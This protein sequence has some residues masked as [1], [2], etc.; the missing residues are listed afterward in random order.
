MTLT[1]SHASYH[2]WSGGAAHG[3]PAFKDP[4][5]TTR[6]ADR[7][8]WLTGQLEAPSWGVVQNYDGAAMS[9]GILNNIAVSPKDNTQGSFF[10]LLRRILD[11]ARGMTVQSL[12]DTFDRQGWV[13]TE[14]GV[15]RTAV[16]GRAVPGVV[17][18]NT[19]S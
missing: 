9:G 10:K 18:R 2:G 19:F 16:D 14:D 8:V 15:L 12:R 1:I 7:A 17:I 5:D 6:H 11:G 4:I 3:G 13:L